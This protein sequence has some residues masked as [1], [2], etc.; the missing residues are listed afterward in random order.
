ML[1]PFSLYPFIA[2]STMAWKKLFRATRKTTTI[3]S[4]TMMQAAA[5]SSA[6][7]RILA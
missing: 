5:T 2:P 1:S 3:G 4:A 6:S 7:M